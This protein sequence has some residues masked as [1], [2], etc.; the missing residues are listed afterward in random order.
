VVVLDT[1][2]LVSALLFPRSLPMQTLAKALNQCDVVVSAATW[3]EF[4]S[5]IQ[6]PKFDARLPLA[7]RLLALTELAKRVREVR[8]TTVLRVCR[9]PKDDPFLALAM[10]A[11][12]SFVVTGDA[13]LLALHP[14]GGVS[15]VSAADF[16]A[17]P[18][19]AGQ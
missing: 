7:K 14:F 3:D 15:I 8:V 9:D 4:A 1:N 10:D 17:L 19:A 18:L 13:D 6:R 5:V 11:K 2:L 12:A 16:L